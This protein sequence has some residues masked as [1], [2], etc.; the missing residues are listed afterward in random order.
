MYASAEQFRNYLNSPYFGNLSFQM[1][2]RLK[3]WPM[4][5][6]V[7]ESQKA[8]VRIPFWNCAPINNPF[9]DYDAIRRTFRG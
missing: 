9:W 6:A 3:S 7:I 8:R 4:L 1:Y 5:G 2:L